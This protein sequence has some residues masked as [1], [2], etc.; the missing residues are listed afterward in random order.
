MEVGLKLSK[1]Y[2]LQT[3]EEKAKMV[4][5]HYQMQLTT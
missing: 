4:N 1:E 2:S 5:I 3:K